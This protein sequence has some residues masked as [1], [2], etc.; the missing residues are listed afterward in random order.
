MTDLLNTLTST[1]GGDTAGQLASAI[2]ASPQQTQQGI[3]AALPMLLGQLNRNT[4]TPEGAQALAGALERDHDGS[5]LGLLGG[6]GLGS[7]LGGLTGGAAQQQSGGMDLGSLLGGLAGGGAQSGGL[8]G[9][10][11][12]LT[13]GG[14][15]QGGGLE[16]M[17]KAMAGQAILGHIFGDKLDGVS[18]AIAGASGLN[19]QQSGN[20]LGMLAPVL[21]GALGKVKR[22]RGLDASGVSD[23]LNQESAQA[24]QAT[25]DSLLGTLASALDSDGDGDLKDELLQKAAGA[26]FGKLFGR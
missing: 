24:R 15:Q 13:G 23:L 21:M 9:L 18:S 16:G 14:Q 20:L 26:A 25:P 2:G 3:T 10:L 19:K 22:D 6:G 7:L 1:L 8:G 4:N 11:G 5:V 17:M 12:Q